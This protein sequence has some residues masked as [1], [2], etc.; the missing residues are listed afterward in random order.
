MPKCTLWE[1][2]FPFLFTQSTLNYNLININESKLQMAVP[3]GTGIRIAFD[4]ITHLRYEEAP[5]YMTI[6][7][8]ETAS[9]IGGNIYVAGKKWFSLNGT[10]FKKTTEPAVSN[11]NENNN[12]TSTCRIC[13]E[14]KKTTACIPCGHLFGCNNCAMTILDTTKKCPVCRQDIQNTLRIFDC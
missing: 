6:D 8:I 11:S 7:P 1:N 4:G 10:W 9:T 12:T 13:W 5:S 2:I 3:V 14:N